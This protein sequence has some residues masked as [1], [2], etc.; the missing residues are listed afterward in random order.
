MENNKFKID[1]N[2]LTHNN[3]EKIKKSIDCLKETI[4]RSN[5]H[6][7]LNKPYQI[8]NNYNT[9]NS[10]NESPYFLYSQRENYNP[11]NYYSNTNRNKSN[12]SIN[13]KDSFS[14]SKKLNNISFYN[15][16]IT[17][18]NEKKFAETTNSLYHPDSSYRN[19]YFKTINSNSSIK[20]IYRSKNKKDFNNNMNNNNDP[21]KIDQDK[22][23]NSIDKLESINKKLSQK[24]RNIIN[25]YKSSITSNNLVMKK[26]SE[27]II[28]LEKIKE[29][30]TKIKNK[31]ETLKINSFNNDYDKDK[32]ELL[33]KNKELNLQIEQKDIIIL[34]LKNKINKI[35]NTDN[36]INYFNE[37]NK[38]NN[39]IEQLKNKI[40]QF[41]KEISKQEEIINKN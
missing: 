36:K 30:N 22:I 14:K 11:N 18:N 8:K 26:K 16:N 6:L 33:I 39:E 1:Y 31:I 17:N 25:N 32:K 4:K 7:Y 12:S 24:Y 29:I 10:K 19:K 34:E 27:I 41:N 38:A 13:Q 35:I 21:N 23:K 20:R 37:I 2:D 28:N 15:I 5:S 3:I 40:N 9:I